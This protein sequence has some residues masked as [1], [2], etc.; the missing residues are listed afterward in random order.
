[1]KRWVMFCEAAGDHRTAATLIDEALALRCAPWVREQLEVA[2]ESVRVWHDDAEAR[3]P[4][5]DLH[6]VY[7][8]A[9]R[10]GV[11]VPYGHFGGA[12]AAPGAKLLQTVQLIARR[13][14]QLD[15][16]ADFEAVVLVW[17]MDKQR[18]GRHAGLAQAAAEG[19]LPGVALVLGCPDPI[20]ETWVLAGFD[21]EDDTERARLDAERRALGFYP[22]EEPHRLTAG[23]EH[24]LK[25]AKRV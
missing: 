1:M 25:H 16:D 23:D 24:G 18:G 19:T 10:L 8:L 7:A 12:P 2:P 17:D 3:R 5:F 22:H 15:R 20:R 6:V 11:K 4:W 13:M 14:Q 21:P 9:R